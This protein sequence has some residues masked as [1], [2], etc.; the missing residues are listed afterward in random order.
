MPRITNHELINRILVATDENRVDWQPT[1]SFNQ[2]TASFAGKWTLLIDRNQVGPDQ[3]ECRLELKN[4]EGDSLLTVS[5]ADDNRIPEL[6]ELARR[7]AL[8]IDDALADLLNEI[9]KPKN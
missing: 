4:S 9:D 7:H 2:F 1:A 5:D 6:H 8:K 3:F